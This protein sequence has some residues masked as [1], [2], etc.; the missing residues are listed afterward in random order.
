MQQR[1]NKYLRVS[2]SDD[3]YKLDLDDAPIHPKND[4]LGKSQGVQIA[5]DRKSALV[6]PAGIIV[7]YINTKADRGFKFTSPKSEPPDRSLSLSMMPDQ[8]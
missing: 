3:Q 7:D 2:V 1:G 6:L 4:Y 8:S 5:V